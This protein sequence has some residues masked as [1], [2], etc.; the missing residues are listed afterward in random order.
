MTAARRSRPASER[1]AVAAA[2]GTIAIAPG[3]ALMT[4]RCVPEAALARTVAAQ[5]GTIAD[6]LADPPRRPFNGSFQAFCSVS[7]SLRPSL[8]P[9]T[10]ACVTVNAARMVEDPAHADIVGGI[11]VTAAHIQMD[12]VV[13]GQR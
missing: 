10:N 5:T 7:L 2:A 8:R 1:S 4:Q 9:L 13:K 11:L 12:N 3:G 6:R